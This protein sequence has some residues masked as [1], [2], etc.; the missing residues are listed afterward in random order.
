MVN[1]DLKKS[2]LSK[3]LFYRE[4][5]ICKT[6]FE[7]ED[8]N[9][10]TCSFKCHEANKTLL[11]NIESTELYI[12]QNNFACCGDIVEYEGSPYKI[13]QTNFRSEILITGI[14]KFIYLLQPINTETGL[15]RVELKK[16]FKYITSK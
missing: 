14:S 12:K 8:K 4:C 7:T 10:L 9:N 15:I 13:Y 1:K 2:R 16:P 6:V 5:P 3:N 11:I